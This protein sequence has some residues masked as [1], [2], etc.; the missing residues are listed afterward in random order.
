MLKVSAPCLNND[1]EIKDCRV[2]WAKNVGNDKVT[3][4]GYK[5]ARNHH[6]RLV[7]NTQRLAPGACFFQ[8]LAPS[9]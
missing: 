3:D 8:R 7:Q 4:P 1:R 9:N 5:R 6:R 2:S